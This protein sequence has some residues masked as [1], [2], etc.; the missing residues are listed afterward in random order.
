MANGEKVRFSIAPQNIPH[1]LG[2]DLYALR[3]IIKFDSNDPLEMIKEL[4]TKDYELL[5]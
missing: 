1:L 5:N 2:I 4:L 3:G